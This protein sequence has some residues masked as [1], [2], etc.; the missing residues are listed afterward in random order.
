MQVERLC[1]G[2]G[3]FTVASSALRAG[4]WL[5]GGHGARAIRGASASAAIVLPTLESSLSAACRLSN[6]GA[7]REAAFSALASLPLV[8]DA[9][10]LQR[11]ASA[12]SAAQTR[13][14]VI[15]AVG[16]LTVAMRSS[17][18]DAVSSA[19]SIACQEAA[20]EVGFPTVEI[21]R[22]AP[23]IV[24]VLAADRVGRGLVTEI[25]V[26]ADSSS[27][28]E[29]EVLGVSS[30]ECESTLTAFEGA[31]ARRG[32]HAASVGRRPT[33]GVPTTDTAREFLGRLK[34]RQRERRRLAAPGS[35]A[36]PSTQQ[37]SASLSS[38]EQRR[39]HS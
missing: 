13:G 37:S 33:G 35:D 10:L 21:A 22:P 11:H 39:Q 15:D 29:S 8:V 2:R 24:R 12:L 30:P 9:S 23:G 19:L 17:H 32:L 14:A 16:A 27:V 25:R 36:P 1:A 28:L 20:I 3:R 7:M 18:V 38:R 31:L 26:S 6:A 34:K 4:G 5:R